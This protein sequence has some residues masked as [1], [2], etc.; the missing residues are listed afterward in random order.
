[1]G[2]SDQPKVPH[3]WFGRFIVC[4]CSDGRC[5]RVGTT[6]TS[7]WRS[8]GLSKSSFCTR[9]QTFTFRTSSRDDFG[10]NPGK[11]PA[12]PIV[13]EIHIL[14]R[15]RVFGV[16]KHRIVGFLN[17]KTGLGRPHW[18]IACFAASTHHP[19]AFADIWGLNY[20]QISSGCISADY[21]P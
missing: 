2:V 21:I 9:F 11:M 13:A 5:W 6:R 18:Q 15:K 4:F 3:S 17:T 12:Q 1:M 19:G 16:P 20:C 14:G 10:R 8:L 7:L